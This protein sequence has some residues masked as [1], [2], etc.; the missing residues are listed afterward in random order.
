[1]NFTEHEQKYYNQ[2]VNA[3]RALSP[4]LIYLSAS[5][6]THLEGFLYRLK[7]PLSILEKIYDRKEVNDISELKDIN[8]YTVICDTE[9]FKEQVN[10]ICSLLQS[11]GID[12][13]KFKNTMSPRTE[14]QPYAGLNCQLEINGH[15][16]ELQFHTPDSCYIERNINHPLYEVARKPLISDEKKQLISQEMAENSNVIMFPDIN[17]IETSFAN[18]NINIDYDI[19][20]PVDKNILRIY[21]PDNNV[22]TQYLTL[23]QIKQMCSEELTYEKIKQYSFSNI[24]DLKEDYPQIYNNQLI[25][26]YK[27]ECIARAM[28]EAIEN[29]ELPTMDKIYDML[30]D[31]NIDIKNIAL[32]DINKSDATREVLQDADLFKKNTHNK[33]CIIQQQNIARDFL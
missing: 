10:N 25:A 29:G 6:N 1:M 14:E 17:G 27:N 11:S 5:Q 24:M 18:T 26:Q 12:I 2:C 20:I 19:P 16:F 4:I 31:E 13:K 7:A 21:Y 30:T 33:E 15:Q 3:E 32:E 23:N 8:R 9:R 28:Q 22:S